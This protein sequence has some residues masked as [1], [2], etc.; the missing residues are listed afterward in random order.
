MTVSSWTD[1]PGELMQQGE[2]GEGGG[3]GGDRV[4]EQ[5]TNVTKI[6]LI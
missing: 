3:G 4:E 2:R 1:N 5:Q 6:E